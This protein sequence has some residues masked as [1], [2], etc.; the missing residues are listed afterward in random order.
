M[1]SVPAPKG[2]SV[3]FEALKESWNEYLL[4]DGR[5]LRFKAVVSK[6]IKTDQIGPDGN[7]IYFVTSSS[8]VQVFGPHELKKPRS[9]QQP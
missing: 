9:K 1:Q 2:E 5:I 3:E 7:P 8:V 6:I 4:E